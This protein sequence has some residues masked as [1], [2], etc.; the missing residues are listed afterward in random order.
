M[1]LNPPT[2]RPETG[3]TLQSSVTPNISKS[4]WRP[5]P[6]ERGRPVVRA[7][8][9][10]KL[11]A[12][13]TLHPVPSAAWR[14]ASVSLRPAFGSQV[15]VRSCNTRSR[16]TIC[17]H[18]YLQGA[19]AQGPGVRGLPGAWLRAA[20][21]YVSAENAP[22]L[23]LTPKPSRCCARPAPVSQNF[24]PHPSSSF[25]PGRLPACPPSGYSCLPP[26]RIHSAA[27]RH[28]RPS[29]YS[30]RPGRG[31]QS[32]W[33]RP[34]LPVPGVLHSN[35]RLQGLPE[36]PRLWVSVPTARPAWRATP[37]SVYQ[38][39]RCSHGSLSSEATA[40]RKPSASRLRPNTVL[41][42]FPVR[43]LHWPHAPGG[44]NRVWVA[45]LLSLQE[46]VAAPRLA[47]ADRLA[48]SRWAG[49]SWATLSVTSQGGR[50]PL[51]SWRPCLPSPAPPLPATWAGC[52]LFS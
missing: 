4:N 14:P 17:F 34:L 38:T 6:A 29:R 3:A 48:G 21:C 26:H 20:A 18:R 27:A 10:G 22:R 41:I 42:H 28:F 32:S 39:S 50:W 7:D 33:E 12:A 35:P 1:L 37:C 31:T 44:E 24:L 5:R 19:R 16:V 11:Q 8:P 2:P 9:T 36:R 45:P 43:P 49:D 30:A 15:V 47:A 52:P 51:S 23:S 40:S 13:A 25:Q 46:L